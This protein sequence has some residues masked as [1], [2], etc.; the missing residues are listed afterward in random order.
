MPVTELCYE[1]SNIVFTVT[2]YFFGILRELNYYGFV[3]QCVMRESLIMLNW[4]WVALWNS[5]SEHLAG[6]WI[7]YYWSEFNA[8]GIMGSELLKV[9][10][11]VNALCDSSC[12]KLKP[13]DD[14]RSGEMVHKIKQD[15]EEWRGNSWGG[16]MFLVF[17][18]RREPCFSSGCLCSFRTAFSVQSDFW[19]ANTPPLVFHCASTARP[20]I[21]FQLTLTS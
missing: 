11:L 17:I 1:S 19:P 20:S 2:T 9:E 18:V 14:E 12:T 6:H 21:A 10:F 7:L 4:H 8:G 16:E 5:P 15:S 13:Q 3:D